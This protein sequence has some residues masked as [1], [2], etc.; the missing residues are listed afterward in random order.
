MRL[1]NTRLTGPQVEEFRLA[2]RDAFND[3][4]KFKEFLFTQLNRQLD[5][6]TPREAF[7]TEIYN[8]VTAADDEDWTEEFLKSARLWRPTN[9]KLLI[10]AQQ[11]GLAPKL[12]SES[13]IKSTLERMVRPNNKSVDAAVWAEKLLQIVGQICRIEVRDG[14]ETSF[15]TGFLLG[16]DVIMT[17]YHVVEGVI[18]GSIAAKNV[19]ILFDFK[20]TA[21][22]SLPGIPYY[23]AENHWRIDHSEYSPLDEVRNSWD[24]PCDEDKLDYA[25]MR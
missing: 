18:K 15:G 6:I 2:I 20:K 25:L 17:N 12:P 8:V 14:G 10:F 24:R 11:F 21:N 4:Q 23:L 1:N 19:S 5:D 7:P 3:R 9:T 16:P 13:E 22:T